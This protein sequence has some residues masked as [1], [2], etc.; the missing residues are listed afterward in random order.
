MRASVVT[1]SACGCWTNPGASRCGTG[2]ERC[3]ELQIPAFLLMSKPCPFGKNRC[4]RQRCIYVDMELVGS[5][6][7]A[8]LWHPRQLRHR[9][10][11]HGALERRGLLHQ[12]HTS[13]GRIPSPMGYWHY[14]DALL[15]E[16]GVAFNMERELTGLSLRWAGLDDLLMHVARRLTDFT[17]LM[18]LITQP[19]QENRQLETIRLVPS[20]TA[21]GD[22]GGSQWPRQSS[23]PASAA[24]G[25]RRTHSHGT[26]GHR[27]ARAG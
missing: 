3:L 22:A 2:V 25:R 11:R 16:P 12:P 13:A 6:P 14:V 19:Q 1:T 8:T 23:Q 20:G 18:S 26:L 5:A 4:C 10:L 24:W 27:P 7:G 21:S 9:S 15:P 17:G